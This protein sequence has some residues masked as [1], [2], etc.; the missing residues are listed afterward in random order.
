[1]PNTESNLPPARN[2]SRPSIGVTRPKACST[3]TGVTL[4]TPSPPQ[5]GNTCSRTNAITGT[6][7]A[8]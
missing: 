7:G 2:S 6:L 3:N 5:R 1:M 4:P 8:W